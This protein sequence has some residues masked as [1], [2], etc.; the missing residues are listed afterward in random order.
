MGIGN[1]GLS[2][3]AIIFVIALIVFGPRRL[4]EIGKSLGSAMREFRRSLNQIQREIEEVDPVKP[5]RDEMR[6]ILRPISGEPGAAATKSIP[7]VTP[8]PD[9]ESD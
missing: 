5:A 4:P 9:T 7:S 8:R 6:S 1:L 3:M 2:E